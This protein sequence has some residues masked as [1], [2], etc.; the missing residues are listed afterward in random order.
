MWYINSTPNK[1]GAYSPPQSTPFDGAIP[2]TDEQA[3]MLVQYNGFVVISRSRSPQRRNG[4]GRTW[5]F[6]LLWRGWSY[7]RVRAGPEIL[8]PAVGRRPH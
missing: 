2:L 5:T 8:P 7:E 3:D 1:S 6:W 4:C